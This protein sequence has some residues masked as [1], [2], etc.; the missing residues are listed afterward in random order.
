[1][2]VRRV[3]C[4]ANRVELGLRALWKDFH[5]LLVMDLHGLVKAPT[6]VAEHL[7]PAQKGLED[8]PRHHQEV[9]LAQEH[10]RLLRHHLHQKRK[11]NHRCDQLRSESL[12][13]FLGLLLDLVFEKVFDNFV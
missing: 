7:V 2:T 1:M 13:V 6:A 11:M 12:D 5:E 9:L 10:A 4:V 8:E 3:Y